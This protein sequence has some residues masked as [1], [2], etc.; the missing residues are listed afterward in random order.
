MLS[1]IMQQ[2]DELVGTMGKHN[3][4]FKQVFG[5]DLSMKIGQ[6]NT[7]VSELATGFNQLGSS[8]VKL[9]EALD[10][11]NETQT[12]HKD[13]LVDGFQ[14]LKEFNVLFS[15]HLKDHVTESTTFEKQDRKSVV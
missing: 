14:E 2:G 3:A 12:T 7:N 1:Q 4:T 9:P 5:S 8:I 10:V 11:I 6:V 13:L 15:N